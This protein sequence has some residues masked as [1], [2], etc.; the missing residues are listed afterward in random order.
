MGSV[1][2]AEVRQAILQDT[3]LTCCAGIA[4]NKLL[5][6]LVAGWRK[7]NMQT[8]LLPEDAESLLSGLQARDIPG[9][10]SEKVNIVVSNYCEVTLSFAS[11]GES[12]LS[13]RYYVPQG[14][15]VQRVDNTILWID[16][17]IVEGDGPKQTI[18]SFCK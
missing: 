7:P 9:I 3:G 10:I 17:F 15:V 13:Y 14:P 16:H 6:K 11:C 4:H 5:A 1:I 8:T 2:A 18:L 12:K